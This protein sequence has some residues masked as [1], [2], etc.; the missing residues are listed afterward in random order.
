MN[1]KDY[2]ILISDISNI[3][4]PINQLLYECL[5]LIVF[6]YIFNKLSFLNNNYKIH[7]PFVYLI[8]IICILLDWF[9]WNNCLQ[10]SLFT[11]IL[12]IYIYYNFNISS[13]ISTFI[14][15]INESKINNKINRKHEKD[16]NNIILEKDRK[17]KEDQEE[18]EKITFIP[19]DFTPVINPE[20]YEKKLDGINEINS[21]YIE[22]KKPV[23]IFSLNYAD[24]KLNEL[25]K[26]PQYRENN[27]LTLNSNISNDLIDN[28]N[29]INHTNNN[30]INTNDLINNHNDNRNIDLF[31]KPKKTFLD[32]RWLNIKQQTYND[33]CN[34]CTN[35]KNNAIC[36]VVK[37][38]EGLEECTNQNNSVNNSQL[39]NIS[40]NSVKPIYKF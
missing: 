40:N 8:F 39:Q 13:T 17:I 14:N 24:A 1:H 37:Y 2:N 36:T 33:I 31:R 10:T 34:D 7:K 5:I 22:N 11:S 27:A 3:V 32:D 4:K 16:M 19:K 29:H 28:N 26:T 15:V 12:Y 35:N 9:I 38:G 23:N 21:A 18:I 25:R 6:Y 30:H 20:P